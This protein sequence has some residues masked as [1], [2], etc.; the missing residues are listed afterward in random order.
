M[1]AMEALT[2]EMGHELMQGT[3]QS[4]SESQQAEP[5]E[6]GCEECNTPM[7]KRG[8]RKKRVV[9]LRGETDVKRSYYQCDGCGEACFPPRYAVRVEWKCFSPAFAKQMVWLSSLLPYAQSVE[10]MEQIGERYMST[11]AVRDGVS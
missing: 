1:S 9:T 10:V 5:N 3:V 6:V 7:H 4:L 8:K 11:F 2:G